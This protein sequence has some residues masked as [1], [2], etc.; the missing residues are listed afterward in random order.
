MGLTDKE[1][2][3][4]IRENPYLQY[5][6]GF[7]EYRNEKPFDPSLMVRFRQRFRQRFRIEQLN[8]INKTLGSRTKKAMTIRLLVSHLPQMVDRTSKTPDKPRG[9]G[10]SS[11]WMP[12][13]CRP[14]SVTPPTWVS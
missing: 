9:T 11:S 14:I 7:K 4:Q 12:P 1:T 3:E 2:V 13:V 5:F 6:L 10:V 8:T